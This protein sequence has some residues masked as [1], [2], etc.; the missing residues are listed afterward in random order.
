MS[1]DF[2]TLKYNFKT[3]FIQAYREGSPQPIPRPAVYLLWS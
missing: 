2:N 1:I 3:L